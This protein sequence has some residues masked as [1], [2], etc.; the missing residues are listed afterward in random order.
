MEM[1]SLG[2]FAIGEFLTAL[3]HLLYLLCYHYHPQDCERIFIAA[4][5]RVLF[6]SPS[7]G[8]LAYINHFS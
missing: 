3:I 8:L 7:A 2:D 1:R 5:S 4:L 6:L